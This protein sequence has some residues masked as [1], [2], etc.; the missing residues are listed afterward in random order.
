MENFK[1]LFLIIS[2]KI[3]NLPV[4]F[5]ISILELKFLTFITFYSSTILLNFNCFYSTRN[6]FSIILNFLSQLFQP[7]FQFNRTNFYFSS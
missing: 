1:H 4:T 6:H 3:A 2:L 5:V 7:F